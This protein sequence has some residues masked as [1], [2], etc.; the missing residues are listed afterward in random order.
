ME[1]GY[2]IVDVQGLKEAARKM[3]KW[4]KEQKK[5]HRKQL[6]VGYRSAKRPSEIRIVLFIFMV[7]R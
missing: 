5:K 2:N 3:K 6:G 7:R 1:R 4:A